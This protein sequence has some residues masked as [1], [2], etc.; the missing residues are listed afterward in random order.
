LFEGFEAYRQTNRMLD[1][2]FGGAGAMLAGVRAGWDVEGVEISESAVK[3]ALELGLKAVHGAVEEV[4]YPDDAFD[5]VICSEVLEHVPQPRLLVE[6]MAR[7][8]RPGGLLWATTPHGKGVSSKLLGLRWSV[9]CPPEH[10][11]LFSIRGLHHLFTESGLSPEKFLTENVN[12]FEAVNEVKARLQGRVAIPSTFARVQSNYKILAK[13][14]SKPSLTL[15]K[16]GVQA[17]LHVT[18]LGDSLKVWA[19]KDAHPARS[20]LV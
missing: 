10:L 5:V 12:P 3:N 6:E 20:E 7:I 17:A 2:G 4:G 15:A 11:Q 9:M 16:R 14:Y 1:V 13:V 18:R 8:V 19:T